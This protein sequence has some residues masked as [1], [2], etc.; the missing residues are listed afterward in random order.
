MQKLIQF[1]GNADNS[2]V[3][4][5]ILKCGLV[6]IVFL[7]TGA[8]LRFKIIPGI[9]AHLKKKAEK[10]GKKGINADIIDSFK[11]PIGVAVQLIGLYIAA[12]NL[13]LGEKTLAVLQPVALK[14][15]R[16]SVIML[17]AV[18]LVRATAIS[19]LLFGRISEKLSADKNKT[20]VSFITGLYKA[21]VG[22]FATVII[23]SELG[24]DINGLLAGLGLGGLTFA[25]AAQ[26]MAG[27]LFGGMIII[28]DKPF[29]VGDWINTAYGEGVVEDITFRYTKIR[30]FTDELII[31][32][33]AKLSSDAVTNCTRMKMRRAKF[34]VGVCYSTPPEKL[35]AAVRDIKAA[36]CE[37]EGVVN[38]N[39]EVFLD[40]FAESSIN[41]AVIFYTEKTDFHGHCAI[42]EK[43][44]YSIME[45][46]EKHGISMAFPS[47][48]VYIENTGTRVNDNNRHTGQ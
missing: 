27:N 2:A 15:V 23:I 41:I 22:I 40:E 28:F 11:M 16:I 6:F 25:L 45:I 29:E 34:S 14:T 36:L 18:G 19:Q 42:K 4:F 35:S 43:M 20:A 46:L 48:S 31:V 21:L 7:I 33:N 10:N 13:P 38:G 47:R 39:Y 32:P 17:T 5:A 1:F 30:A 37:C 26:D 24:Y 44:N 9:A 8:L 12:V 3:L